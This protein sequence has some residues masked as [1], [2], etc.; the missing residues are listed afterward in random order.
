[1]PILM[2]IIILAVIAILCAVLLTV[3]NIFFGVKENELVAAVREEL[4]GAN[5]GACGFSGCDGY[6]KALSE[7]DEWLG[8]FILKL[9]DDDCLI[10]TADHGCDPGDIS[11]DHTREYTPLIIYGDKITPQN[12]GTLSGFDHIASTVLDMLDIDTYNNK[13]LYKLI[14]K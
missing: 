12:L 11:T 6:A 3:S 13:S 9:Q 4:P 5:C 7:F 2:P 8:K 14:K 10:I 1:M